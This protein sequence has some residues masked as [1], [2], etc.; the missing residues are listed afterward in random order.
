LPPISCDMVLSRNSNSNTG[1]NILKLLI[2]VKR[3]VDV[4]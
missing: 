3:V 1:P 2:D 4:K